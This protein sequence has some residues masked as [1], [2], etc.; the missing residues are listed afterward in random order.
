MSVGAG[1]RRNG[2]TAKRR[3]AR[4]GEG[5]FDFVVCVCWHREFAKLMLGGIYERYPKDGM[6]CCD[7]NDRYDSECLTRWHSVSLSCL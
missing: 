2:G 1:A 3:K 4:S 6:V 7:G 5:Y